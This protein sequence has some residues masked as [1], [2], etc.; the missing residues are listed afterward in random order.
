M[1]L[2]KCKYC[3]ASVR[4]DLSGSEVTFY[5]FKDGAYGLHR[6]SDIEDEN[7]LWYDTEAEALS[8]RWNSND[9][10]IS[11]NPEYIKKFSK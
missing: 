4:V 1:N 7:V 3:V 11:K 9:C 8:N 5:A 6:V 2:Y 10:V